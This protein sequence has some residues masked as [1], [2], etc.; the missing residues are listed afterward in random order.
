MPQ[1]TM[2][3]ECKEEDESDEQLD[4]MSRDIT[5]PSKWVCA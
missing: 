4:D 1:V 5:K 3:A 2:A